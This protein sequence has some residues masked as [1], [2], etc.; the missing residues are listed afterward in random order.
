MIANALD[1]IDDKVERR[2]AEQEILNRDFAR[3]VCDRSRGLAACHG[4]AAF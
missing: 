2:K 4:N 3:G 1:G